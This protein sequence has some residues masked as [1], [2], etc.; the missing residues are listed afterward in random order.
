M[1]GA[2][3]RPLRPRRARRRDIG[4][5]P[6]NHR[7]IE[8]HPEVCF[9]AMKG[10]PLDYSKHS[11]NGQAERRRLIAGAGIDLPDH[12]LDAGKVPSD[13]LLDAAVAAWTA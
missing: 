3:P 2:E 9:R 6:G 4:I 8:V 10:E 12:I 1:R 11:W 7:V 13:D 5:A